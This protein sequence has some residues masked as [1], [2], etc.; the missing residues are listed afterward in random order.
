MCASNREWDAFLKIRREL[1]LGAADA[2]VQMR[3]LLVQFSRWPEDGLSD[4][5]RLHL[6]LFRRVAGVLADEI[7]QN[8]PGKDSRSRLA[9]FE[10]SYRF[11]R[12]G[13]RLFPDRK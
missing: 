12:V 8:P 2:V 4:A 1:L 5:Q 9:F 6:A 3:P 10:R 7:K 13:E 11:T